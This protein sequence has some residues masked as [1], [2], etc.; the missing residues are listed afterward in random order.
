MRD[1]PL[2]PWQGLTTEQVFAAPPWIQIS[3][4]KVRL[5]DGRTVDDYHQIV[6]PD[7]VIIVAQ[8]AE[9]LVVLERMYKHGIGR[10]CLMLPAGGMD[11]GEDPLVTA[12]RELLEETGYAAD[13]W[14]CLGQFVCHANYGCSTSH[15]YLAQNARRVAEPDAGDLEEIQIVLQNH[16]EIAAAIR[17]GEIR[18]LGVMAALALVLNPVFVG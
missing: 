8:T 16:R 3:R 5:P 17:N 6:L 10:V 15:M 12:K 18:S 4:Q 7:H 11:P 2:N 13:N 9:K 1:S 14:K